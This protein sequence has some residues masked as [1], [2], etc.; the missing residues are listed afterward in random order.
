MITAAEIMN[1]N[2]PT[3]S[4]DSTV[5][6]AIDFMRANDFGFAAV[7]ASEDRFHGVLTESGMMRIYLRHQAHPDRQALIL[8]RDC[9]DP[10]QLVQEKEI[11]PEVVKK[12]MTAVGNRV[13]VINPS[14]AV[15]GHISSKDILPMFSKRSLQ[16]NNSNKVATDSMRSGLYLYE[17]FFSKSPFMMHS[18][19]GKGE[20]QMA[21]EMLHNVLG[22]EY[23]Q[24]IGKT[25]YDLYPKESHEKAEQGIKSIFEKGY[26]RVVQGKMLTQADKIIPVELISRVLLDQ[27][28]KP[29]GTITVSRPLDMETLLSC[30]PEV[31]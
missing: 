15:V 9:F 5:E 7:N 10:M 13:F 27:E 20:I 1:R 4:F 21:N 16:E 18:V 31:D 29:V 6:S 28:Q 3:L 23:G 25:I 24:L 12:V 8:Y 14:G 26:H 30:L 22:Y 2:T 17:N 19:N 11:F